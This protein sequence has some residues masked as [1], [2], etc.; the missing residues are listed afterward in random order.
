M[1]VVIIQTKQYGLL[2][3]LI[4][5]FLAFL[6]FRNHKPVKQNISSSFIIKEMASVLAPSLTLIFKASLA[7]GILPDDWKKAFVIPVYKKG[8]RSCA[9]NYRPFSLTGLPCK[10][11]EHI[12]C[13]NIFSHLE[14]HGILCDEQHGFCQKRS[15]ET[16]LITAVNDFAIALNN[17]EQVDA[18]FLDLSKAFDRDWASQVIMQ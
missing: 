4:V 8:D 15:C 2:S 12:I 18:I 14:E 3:S 5:S 17:S 11:M 13:S 16:Q 10:I 7:Q 9:P 6:L 1:L